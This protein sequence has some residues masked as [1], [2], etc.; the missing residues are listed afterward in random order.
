MQDVLDVLQ[1]LPHHVPPAAADVVADDVARGR[2]ALI[3]RRRRRIA[4]S[5]AAVAAVAAVAVGATQLGASAPAPVAKEPAA[6]SQTSRVR[7]VAYT[8]A[9]PVGFKVSTV[10][11]GWTVVSSDRTAFVVAPPGAKVTHHRPR[12]PAASVQDPDGQGGVSFE[13]R[14]AVML[15]GMSRLPSRSPVTKV[16]V[17]GKQGLLGLA[18]GGDAAT[19]A[20]WL[21]FPDGAGHQ[22]LVQVPRSLGLTDDQI[23]RFAQGITVTGEAQP[24]AG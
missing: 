11:A 20:A 1:S 3:R 13:G 18:D 8:G 7:L 12:R 15:Q 4:C 6:T 17:N 21:I 14:I 10:P 23:V 2:R 24:A 5:S 9:Q 19:R 22:V 16:T